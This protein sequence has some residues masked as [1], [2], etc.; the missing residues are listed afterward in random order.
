MSLVH[1]P[2][3]IGGQNNEFRGRKAETLH[4]TS[5]HTTRLA[6]L[7]RPSGALG[8]FCWLSSPRVETLGYLR[9]PLA[10]PGSAS[11]EFPDTLIALDGRAWKT[12]H[13]DVRCEY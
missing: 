5:G 1:R 4:S 10:G 8:R 11:N 3:Q 12:R 13:G 6:G 9:W 2:S 7:C